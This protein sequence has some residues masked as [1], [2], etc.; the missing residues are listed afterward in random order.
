MCLAAAAM[1]FSCVGRERPAIIFAVNAYPKAVSLRIG[2]E[3]RPVWGVERL[4]AAGIS[5][6]AVV[7]EEGAY[8]VY[9]RIAGSDA[10]QRLPI[11]LG[12]AECRIR[13]GTVSAVV[14]DH[15]GFIRVQ[16]FGDDPRPGARVSLLNATTLTLKTARL[17][18]P[19]EEAF[20]VFRAE[21]LSAGSSTVFRSVV[22]GEYRLEAVFASRRAGDG[23]PAQTVVSCGEPYYTIICCFIRDNRPVFEQQKVDMD[24]IAP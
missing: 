16:T 8:P 1:L 22:P 19:R 4:A 3:P 2:E 20:P 7:R 6:A 18:A 14:V 24:G 5:T 15:R 13:P 9:Y 12:E 10:W 21:D 11:E 23:A 17:F